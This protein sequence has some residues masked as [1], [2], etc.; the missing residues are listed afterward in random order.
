MSNDEFDEKPKSMGLMSPLGIAGLVAI[1]VP[2]VLSM[3]SSSTS[4]VNGVVVEANYFDPVAVFAGGAGVLLGLL[5]GAI[6]KGPRLTR[7]ISALIIMAI[8]GRHVVHGLGIDFFPGAQR[9]G[10]GGF[11]KPPSAQVPS[12]PFCDSDS[13]EAC[14]ALCDKG[15]ADACDELGV[16][17]AKGE[18]GLARDDAKA[19]ALFIKA[20]ELKDPQA[21]NNI[22]FLFFQG[23]T[24]AE[25][26]KVL[27]L[28]KQGCELKNASSC[29]M[30]GVILADGKGVE[31]DFAGA[32]GFYDRAC[33]LGW[34]TGC[35]NAARFYR[36][37][38]GVELDLEKAT[39][40]FEK[41][42]GG[43][44]GSACNELGAMLADEDRSPEDRERANTMFER[45][46]E[47]KNPFGC[48]NLG[49]RLLKTDPAKAVDVLDKACTGARGR[50]CEE[51]GLLLYEG[52][53]SVAKDLAEARRVF[54]TGCEA[55]H[56]NS[57]TNEGIM[58]MD[59]E[60]GPVDLDEAA[61]YLKEACDAKDEKACARLGLVLAE[62]DP[63]GAKP[64]LTAA[65]KKKF[66]RACDALKKLGKKKPAKKK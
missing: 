19:E 32:L 42:C 38:K 10:G 20:C 46:C 63:A 34:A 5:L 17:Y 54:A 25:G 15:E 48:S 52:N 49:H 23:L 62:S 33:A 57:C 6:G 1:G 61:E 31:G 27:E 37:G 64:L 53:D 14:P 22:G 56:M 65:C 66:G 16:A 28:T 58:L 43:G 26:A 39:S 3:A 50:A 12:T 47:L 60:G 59:G 36:D 35:Y 13:P 8:G 11:S 51:L 4:T 7:W 29:N 9:A 55:G 41:G 44:E 45:A 18:G 2:M 30:A 40:L 21:C 24:K